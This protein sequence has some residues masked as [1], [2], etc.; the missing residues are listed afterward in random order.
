MGIGR[1]I[2][3]CRLD[4][5]WEIL[6]VYNTS[7]VEAQRL[8]DENSSVE[9]VQADLSRQTRGDRVLEAVGSA[10]AQAPVSKAGIVEFEESGSF[11]ADQWRGRSNE[12]R[13]ERSAR[14]RPQKTNGASSGSSEEPAFVHGSTLTVDGGLINV[15]HLY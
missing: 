12:S 10:G 8:A 11:S 13:R 1:A 9:S 3:E 6:C 7:A 2:A 5:D 14:T 15:D 4:D